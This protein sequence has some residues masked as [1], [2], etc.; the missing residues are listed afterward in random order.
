MNP[1]LT[2]STLRDKGFRITY[3]RKQI[4]VIFSRVKKPLSAR[5]IYTNLISKKIN[6][7]R[8]TVYREL[9]FLVNQNYLNPV[10]IKPQEIS[11]EAANLVHHHHLICEVC[12]KVDNITN[13]LADNFE[14]DVFRKKR[15]KIKKHT[16]EFYGVC[17]KCLKKV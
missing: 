2:I 16:L 1:D 17:A 4:I 11:Y 10:Y 14:R 12:G 7:N 5:D 9:E 8:T 15:F 13:C 3:I 6:V